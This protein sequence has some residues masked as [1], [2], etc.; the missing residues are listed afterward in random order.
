MS[1]GDL[2]VR[3]A[4]LEGL[5]LDELRQAWSAEIGGA[6]PKLRTRELMALSLAYRLQGRVH[7]DLPG[8]TKR[9]LAE[10]AR[11]FTEDRSYTPTPGPNL[12]P[13]S[14]LIKE[15]RGYRHEVRVLEDGYSYLGERFA[16]L[17]EVA[18]RITGTKWNGLVFF[19]LKERRR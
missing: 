8:K 3:L 4:G 16:S 15:W 13:G 2:E 14:S 5:T 18:K 12:K 6:P 10:L 19:G 1:A 11:R 9:R 7:G 17:S